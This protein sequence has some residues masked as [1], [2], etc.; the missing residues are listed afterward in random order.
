MTGSSW[1]F[2]AIISPAGSWGNLLL[3]QV[4]EAKLIASLG[5]FTWCSSNQMAFSWQV[6]VTVAEMDVTLQARPPFIVE[7]HHIATHSTREAIEFRYLQWQRPKFYD[8]AIWLHNIHM[9]RKQL[10]ECHCVIKPV[11][12][13]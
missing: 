6:G 12:I 9:E 11:N 3:T 13:K 4:E 1:M 10:H 5:G 8:T 7:G 2:H